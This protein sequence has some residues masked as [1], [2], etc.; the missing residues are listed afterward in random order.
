MERATRRI[1][2]TLIELLVVITI[3][4]ILIAL[5]LP[6]VQAA[7][8]AARRMHC[9]N[10]LRQIGLGLANY[11]S[12]VKKLPPSIVLNG[13]GNAVA[14]NGGWSVQARILPYLE[15]TNLFVQCDFSVNKEE[16]Q[17]QAAIGLNLPVFLCPSLINTAV[18][19]HD[20]GRSGVTGYGVC[21]GDWFIWGGFNGPENRSAFGPNRSR[22]LSEFADG[23]S[24]TLA[25]SEVKT[26]QPTYICDYA[27]LSKVNSPALVPAPTADYLSAA[28]EYLGGCRLYPLGHTEWSDG[29]CHATG[30]STAWTPNAVTLGTPS[31]NEDVDVQ[32][33]NEEQG[34]ATFGAF[35]SRSF[36]PGGVNVLM[37]DGSGRFLGDSIEGYVWRA[38]GTVSGGEALSNAAF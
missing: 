13:A 12:S 38:L 9:A 33:A 8:E 28:P 6:A 17:N 35:T 32:S 7:R 21:M 3:I 23:L 19:V 27:Q 1:A 36:H 15:Q 14:W 18:S 34:G 25:A 30:F 2:F 11:E 16:P 5:L 22:R 20:Y 37:A 24:Q 29:N 31:R 10:N 26:Y 4:G